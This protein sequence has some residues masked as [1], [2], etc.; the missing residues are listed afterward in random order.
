MWLVLLA[1]ISVIFLLFW[2]RRKRRIQFKEE[3]VAP[4]LE[5]TF[6]HIE[7]KGLDGFD[8]SRI[9]DTKLVNRGNVFKSSDYFKALYHGIEFEFSN[10]L[11]QNETTQ[12][13]GQSTT[14]STTTY[15]KGQWLIVRPKK[16]FD[17]RI[18]IIDRDFKYSNPRGFIFKDKTLEK[19]EMESVDFNREFTVYAEDAHSAF[20]LLT[21]PMLEALLK[22]HHNNV[23][24]YFNGSELHIAIYSKE[25]MFEPKFFKKEGL[26]SY[27]AKFYN[28]IEVITRYLEVFEVE[29]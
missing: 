28:S 1:V 10:V 5:E 16:Q 6:D 3:V 22:I 12:T 2:I 17:T 23:S 26:E 7:Y 25:N 24:F 8:K 14:T 9:F 15:F 20:Y 4:L 27:R 29:R 18:Y 13:T 11:I 21:P 19:V